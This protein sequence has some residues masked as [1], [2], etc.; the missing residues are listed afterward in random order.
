MTDLQT[1]QVGF[2]ERASI[3]CEERR[4][5]ERGEE[6]R[7][8][9]RGEERR[10]ENNTKSAI[11][12]FIAK[13]GQGY[14]VLGTCYMYALAG[15]AR[16]L[17]THSVY[18]GPAI[19]GVDKSIERK[20]ERYASAQAIIFICFTLIGLSTYQNRWPHLLTTASVA[21]SK[22]ILHSKRPSGCPS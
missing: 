13:P 12:H 10:E 4:G 3:H 7:G 1:G 20:R 8:E 16:K 6:R 14:L 2:S 15:R 19:T 18:A 22:Q 21:C 5:E 9:R 11:P 17:S